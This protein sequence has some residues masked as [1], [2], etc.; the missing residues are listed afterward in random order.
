[1][2]ITILDLVLLAVMLISG[3]LAM[4]RGFMRE[5]L[6]I[7][8]WG[9]AALVTLYSYQKLLPTAK[10]YIASDT[11]AS[12]AVIAG[13]FI[14]TLIVVSIITVRI[15]DMILDSR[16]GALDRTL[17]FLFG[18]ARGLL[19]VVVAFLFFAWLVPAKQRPDWVSSAKSLTMLQSTG[20]WLMSLLP[21]D[22]ENTILKRFK[23]TK[24]DDEQT[25]AEPA[26]PGSNDGYSKPARDSL[27]Q[28]ID[29]KPATR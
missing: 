23:K 3:L 2:P 5:I 17:G 9:T 8:A 18:L 25:D 14:A 22:P 15:S 11:L 21:D 12:I 7:A 16:I 1:M 28:L 24:P 29:G 6:S 27:K 13:V 4:V 26:N 19:I 20:D 10:T